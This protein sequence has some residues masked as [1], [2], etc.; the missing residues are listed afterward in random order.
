MFKIYYNRKLDKGLTLQGCL[1]N[2]RLQRSHRFNV[3]NK[4]DKC[5]V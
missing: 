3:L 4:Y 1:A 2:F 5:D